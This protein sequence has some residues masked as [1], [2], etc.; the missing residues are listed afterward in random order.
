MRT[1]RTM[2]RFF[3]ILA[4]VTTARAQTTPPS[5]QILI[6]SPTIAWTPTAALPDASV[7]L[8]AV[9]SR[10]LNVSGMQPG[11]PYTI[12]VHQGANGGASTL[13]L[14][15]GC[16][17]YGATGSGFGPLAQISLT[18]AAGASDMLQISYNGTVCS[19]IRHSF[20]SPVQ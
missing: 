3:L 10:T 16:Q 15:T 7:F 19:V 13:V 12:S 1:M 17:W 5:P 4:L 2:M 11:Q 14:G 9:A 20:L 18:S 8:A 6:D